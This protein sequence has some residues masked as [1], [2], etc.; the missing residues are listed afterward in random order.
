M[1]DKN[2]PCAPHG[3]PLDLENP[4]ISTNPGSAEHL[5]VYINGM[6]HADG[7]LSEAQLKALAKTIETFYKAEVPTAG[8]VHAHGAHAHANARTFARA[9]A[10]TRALMQNTHTH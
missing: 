1:V 10:R 2:H 7:E 3:T 5:E 6:G 9:S 8:H 4:D